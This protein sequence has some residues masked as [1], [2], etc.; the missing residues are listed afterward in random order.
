MLRC[1]A[2]VQLRAGG[3]ADHQAIALAPAPVLTLPPLQQHLRL[4]AIAAFAARP[5]SH[6]IE[7]QLLAALPA[8]E[9]QLEGHIHLLG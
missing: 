6:Q 7:L 2:A 8:V 1:A 9:L 5:Q 3:I 4:L